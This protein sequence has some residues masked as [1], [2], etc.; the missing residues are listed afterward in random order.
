[1]EVVNSLGNLCE[2]C[3]TK[4]TQIFSWA[5]KMTHGVYL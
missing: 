1:M 4:I 2:I 5:L 3:V